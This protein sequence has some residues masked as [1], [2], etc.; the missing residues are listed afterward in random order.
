MPPQL[1]RYPLTRW[2]PGYIEV[3]DAAPVARD[4]KETIQHAKGW[5]WDSEE[6][7]RGDSFAVIAQEGFHCFA[8]SGFLGAFRIH[9]KTVRSEMLKPSI[10]SSP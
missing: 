5:R 7:H 4:D 3:Q 1:L 2:V 10:S 9:L 6:I 8:D